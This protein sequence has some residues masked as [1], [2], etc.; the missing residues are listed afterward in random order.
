MLQECL[1]WTVEILVLQGADC[2]K[3]CPLCFVMISV[4]DSYSVHITNIKQYQVED[5]ESQAEF[6][7]ADW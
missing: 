5:T 1:M 7:L 6:L 3:R 2:W 4:K